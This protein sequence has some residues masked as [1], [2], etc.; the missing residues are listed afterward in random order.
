MLKVHILLNVRRSRGGDVSV[1]MVYENL[2]YI[3]YQS[4]TH[5]DDSVSSPT[6]E[7]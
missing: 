4:E 3:A 5:F 1:R 7:S 6:A 2:E